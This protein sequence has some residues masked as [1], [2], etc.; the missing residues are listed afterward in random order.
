MMSDLSATRPE[1]VVG[2]RSIEEQAWSLFRF[3]QPRRP[4]DIK[5]IVESGLCVGC[6]L[7]ESMV[8]SNHIK[9]VLNQE[10]F[11]RPATAENL[12]EGVQH[13]VLTVCPGI[14]QERR[15]DI[16]HADP[17]W[18]VLRETYVAEILD[19]KT[20]FEGSSG[21]AITAIAAEL[22][23]RGDIKAVL[24]VAAD[25]DNPMRSV[26]HVSRTREDVRRATGARYGPVS[27]LGGLHDMLD[28][29]EPFAFVGKPCDV[30]GVRHL[31]RIDER[32]DRLLRVAISFPCGGMPSHHASVR[33]A[34]RYG[35]KEEDV[36]LMRHRGHGCPGP[37][38]IE[39]KQGRVHE[40]N[41]DNTWFKEFGP[42]LQ[43]RCKI[44]PDSVGEQADIVCGDAW[45]I[46]GERN[47]INLMIVRSPVGQKTLEDMMGAGVLQLRPLATSALARMQ[48]HH[49][50]RKTAVGARLL[51]LAFSGQMLPT[52][53]RMGIIR[54]S[55]KGWRSFLE[56]FFGSRLRA[57]QGRNQETA[58]VWFGASKR[59]T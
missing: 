23:D 29:E 58:P 22:L 48:P 33:M 17:V 14:K 21:G 30:A 24:H 52:F 57:S 39:S 43:F 41:F 45:D 20:K 44:C 35:F 2:R 12:N 1:N 6:G 4:N 54:S 36:S 5:S 15:A 34:A 42:D 46:D 26:S 32:V 49:V 59:E 8:G 31:S 47:N 27:S 51:G 19:E 10:G 9:M 3:L 37:T 7:C 40:E 11:L 38:R 50:A 53:K 55:F 28:R 18:G 16:H 13:D 25:H 56:N